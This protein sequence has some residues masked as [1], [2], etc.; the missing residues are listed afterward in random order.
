MVEELRRQ[1]RT[2]LVHCVG[3][4]SRTPTLGTLCGARLRNVTAD[5]ALRDVTA[6]LPEAYPNWAFREALRRL[7]TLRH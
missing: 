1:G 2:V 3:A 5:E 7:E 6:V 4:V